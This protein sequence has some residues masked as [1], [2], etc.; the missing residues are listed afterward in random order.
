MRDGPLGGAEG[1]AGVVAAQLVAR[2][3]SGSSPSPYDGRGVCYLEFGN[4]EVAKVD[5]TFR[6]GKAPVGA[7]EGP[8]GVIAEEKS[9]FGS[10]RVRR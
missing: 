3:R 7:L 8:S 4:D 10:T 6:P 9:A 2:Q 1:Q 5:V